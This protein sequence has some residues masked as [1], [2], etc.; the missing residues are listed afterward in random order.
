VLTALLSG[1]RSASSISAKTSVQ[2]LILRGKT[3]EALERLRAVGDVDAADSRGDTALHAAARVND[4]VV[5]SY[6]LSHNA[7]ASLKN[8]QSDTPLHV[9]VRHNSIDAASLLAPADG[10]LFSRDAEGKTPLENALFIARDQGLE[11]KIY[12]ALLNQKTATLRDPYGQT[13]IHYCVKEKDITALNYCIEKKLP[14]SQ[15]D[16]SGVTPLHLAFSDAKDERNIAMAAALILGGA[17]PA[18]GAYGYFED[19]VKAR[20]PSLRFDDGQTPL[21][22]AAIQGETG[23]V[24][25]LLEHGAAIEAKDISG[26]TPLHEAV[27]YGHVNVVLMLLNRGANPNARD[28]LGKTPLLLIIPGAVQDA[29]YDILMWRGSQVNAKDM[30]G[31][32]VLHIAAMSGAD[33]AVFS[34]LAAAGVDINERNKRGNTPLALAVEYKNT[35][36]IAF[37]VSRGGD[38]YAADADGKTPLIKALDD[39]SEMLSHL[40]AREIITARDSGGNTALHVA[41]LNATPE[42][43]RR[44]PASAKD[45][46]LEEIRLLLDM[47][48]D[49]NSRNKEGSS[50]LLIAVQKNF[51]A[52]AELL[53][54]RGADVFSTNAKNQ[55]P[56]QS[57]L[58][59]SGG[60]RE[61]ILTPA[62]IHA[63]DGSG[64]TALHH[65]AEW[66]LSD[67]ARLLLEK[68]LDPN[69]KNANGETALFK[70][71]QAND[72]AMIA[73]LASAGA[74]IDTRDFMGNTPLH[75]SIRWDSSNAARSLVALGADIDAKNI[76]GKTP[77]GDAA[78]AGRISQVTMLLDS[79][80]DINAADSTGKTIL[81]D[82]IQSGNT[83]V[84][85]TLLAR[86]A[87]P[88]IQEMYGRNAYHEAVTHGNVGIITLIR[89]AGGN[90]LARDANGE[91]PL[92]A[93]FAKGPG[94]IDAVLGSNLNLVDS[95]GNTPVHV[96]V[97]SRA[98]AG[99]LSTLIAKGYNLNR[100]NSEGVTPLML[101]VRQGE[102]DTARILLK[103]GADPY[104]ADNSGECAVSLAVK[105][106]LSILADIAKAMPAK[107]D[108][109]GDGIL[110]YAARTSDG[111]MIKR[112]L[113]MGLDKTARNISGE[114]PYD[115]A[116]R[117][118]NIAA[119]ELLR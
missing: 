68:G 26:S 15:A 64:N 1:C 37:L 60:P 85:R 72:P 14:L 105:G 119:A 90:P 108:M 114:L 9:A 19:A 76:A 18:R 57:A 30:Y 32:N 81:I 75:T 77:L 47:G 52:A 109:S 63:A 113:S 93:A 69:V 51:P 84:V 33:I 23:I 117:W 74:K 8:A 61:W 58:S 111:E 103:A 94:V 29:I 104:I 43:M 12:P 87:S 73:L 49:V 66:G 55:S 65:A 102:I 56:L 97:T 6:L 10:A 36:V 91:T 70:A 80:A 54:A 13:I 42:S 34:K 4:T 3:A 78:R 106:N 100:R 50:P 86:G 82:A 46:T 35:Q 99:T 16:S 101:A 118:H 41:L 53:L 83:E 95:D 39:G 67:A 89:N 71:V 45:S 17:A 115:V 44:L 107:T 96:A 59:A 28:G 40:M 20:N 79:G 11:N 5:I 110:H 2:D 22:F 62:V 21:H 25:Y 7:D 88:M 27:R 98:D 48:S 38:I 112:L 31:D 92:S 116:A 24:S